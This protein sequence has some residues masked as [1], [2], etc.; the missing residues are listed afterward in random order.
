MPPGAI[1]EGNGIRTDLTIV[2][3]SAR[4]CCDREPGRRIVTV[5]AGIEGFSGADGR[6]A[7]I[8]EKTPAG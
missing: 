1:S 6:P 3:V 7:R 8:P 5:P 4:L 2:C